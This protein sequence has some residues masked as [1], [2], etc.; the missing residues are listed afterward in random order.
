MQK[1]RQDC[2]PGIASDVI[3]FLAQWYGPQ[4][5][6]TVH[7]SGSTGPPKAIFLE[8][9]FVAQSALRTLE[10]F[11]L[12]SGQRILLCLP[13]RYIAG[14]LMVIRALL[15][16]LDLCTAEP[17]DD[18]A[19][20]AQCRD[21]P[22]RFAAMVPNQVT[23]LL[24]YPERFE[25]LGALLIGGSA[26][27]AILDTELQ[28]VPTACFASYGMTETATHI[29]LRRIN[30]QNASDRFY[31][32]K[33]IHVGLSE[34][35]CLTIE[36]PGLETPCLFTNDLAE[37]DDYKTFKILGRADNVIISGGI[38]YFPEILEKKLEDLVAYPFFIG[39][40]PDEILGNRIILV[41]ETRADEQLEKKLE[42]FFDQHL[43]RYE[44][45]KDIVFKDK[46]K[47]TET[48]KIIRRI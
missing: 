24:E 10:F 2:P 12:K 35:G 23:K 16:E 20:L 22:F 27:P 37:L 39:A 29:A 13:L 1:K 48:G 38:K 42:A 31:C 45:P 34:K 15:G 47:R 11:N 17:S 26:L 4:N 5:V 36:M 3:D 8:K 21:T 41:I 9:K 18:F 7:T 32:L 44:R 19:F 14:K 30:G 25:A 33:G 6:I 40:L 46:F 28:T 43:N